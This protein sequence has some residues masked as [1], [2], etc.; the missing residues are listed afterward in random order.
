MTTDKKRY[1]HDPGLSCSSN[2]VIQFMLSYLAFSSRRTSLNG[3]SLRVYVAPVPMH[4]L[5]CSYLWN[6]GAEIL[7]APV[8]QPLIRL[9]DALEPHHDFAI[10]QLHLFKHAVYFPIVGRRD[11]AVIAE[12]PGVVGA[13]KLRKNQ[14]DIV[15]LQLQRFGWVWRIHQ[16]TVL[17]CAARPSLIP[18]IV[19]FIG[20]NG[21]RASFAK[22]WRQTLVDKALQ[23]EGRG[24]GGRGDDRQHNV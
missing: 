15:P 14:Y 19:V 11:L 6:S 23:R 20:S 7:R 22:T 2:D 21:E 12:H 3:T 13:D 17:Q 24:A 16:L 4:Q 8:H 1:A 9:K 18:P 5:N 10:A